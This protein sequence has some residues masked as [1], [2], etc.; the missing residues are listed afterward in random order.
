MFVTIRIIMNGTLATLANVLVHPVKWVSGVSEL[1][2][3]CPAL[4]FASSSD[5]SQTVSIGN[6][7]S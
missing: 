1:D 6:Q 5:S 2:H 4:L 7:Y 3:S